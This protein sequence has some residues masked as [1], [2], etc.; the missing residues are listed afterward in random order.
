MEPIGLPLSLFFIHVIFHFFMSLLL[1]CNFCNSE[2]PILDALFFGK[3]GKQLT[4]MALKVKQSGQRSMDQG[5]YS[6][7][8]LRI[9]NFDKQLFFQR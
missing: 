5:V 3:S 8:G 2:L 6:D 7:G 1:L 4:K 9:I